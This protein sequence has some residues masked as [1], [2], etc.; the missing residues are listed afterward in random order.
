MADN[1]PVIPDSDDLPEDEDNEWHPNEDEPHPHRH[2]EGYPEHWH[3]EEA[4]AVL[5]N[6][7]AAADSGGLELFTPDR[8]DGDVGVA[9]AAFQEAQT[10]VLSVLADAFEAIAKANGWDVTVEDGEEGPVLA[11]I[12]DGNSVTAHVAFNG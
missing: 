11:L 12:K 1:E 3:N 5:Y 8:H 4:Q 6:A 9:D 10:N 7:P 2:T